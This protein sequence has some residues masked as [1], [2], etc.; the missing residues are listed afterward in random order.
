M[1][2]VALRARELGADVGTAAFVVALMGIGQ[3]CSSLPSG[4][5]VARVGERRTLVIAGTADAA[6]M[7]LAASAR[8]VVVLGVAIAMS[9]MLWT[10][11]LKPG[12]DS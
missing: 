12:R 10:A 1:P 4:A 5:V 2:V 11:F 9:G 7:L 8:S 6:A 3:L